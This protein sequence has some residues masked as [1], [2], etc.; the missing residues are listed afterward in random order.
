MAFTD[1]YVSSA[2][3]YTLIPSQRRRRYYKEGTGGDNAQQFSWY[4]GA[5]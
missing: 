5:S 3:A 2:G 1:N 4:E